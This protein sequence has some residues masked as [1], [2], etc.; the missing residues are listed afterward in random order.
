MDPLNK[1]CAYAE[2][3]FD[4]ESGKQGEEQIAIKKLTVSHYLAYL[5]NA[6]QSD[7]TCAAN[8]QKKYQYYP[9]DTTTIRSLSFSWDKVRR[10]Q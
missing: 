1:W 6:I 8:F 7:D 9:G 5:K 4:V 3:K 10:L 2:H